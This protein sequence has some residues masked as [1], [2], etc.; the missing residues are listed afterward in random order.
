MGQQEEL[1][2]DEQE[3]E[4]EQRKE[5]Q[6]QEKEKQE[7]ENDEQGKEK[8]EQGKARYCC[9]FRGRRRSNRSR[10]IKTRVKSHKG[11]L[12]HFFFKD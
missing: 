11:T 9:S 7:Q 6:G 12:K 3:Q 10:R 8:D 1:E 4:K 2:Q 5:D